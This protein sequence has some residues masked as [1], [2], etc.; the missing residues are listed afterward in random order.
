MHRK[1]LKHV[2]TERNWTASGRGEGNVFS[3]HWTAT[4]K[5]NFPPQCIQLQE[6]QLQLNSS[7]RIDTLTLTQLT[8]CDF[9]WK[10]GRK[11]FS[12]IKLIHQ[13]SNTAL[14]N[15]VLNQPSA[16]TNDLPMWKVIPVISSVL[17]L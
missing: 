3:L 14:D 2:L 15:S 6:W 13:L 9:T 17:H 12:A 10:N 11:F 5:F 1:E 4:D 8:F 7:F 16:W